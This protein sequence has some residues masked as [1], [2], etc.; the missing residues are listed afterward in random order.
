V[1]EFTERGQSC[2]LE[3][4]V[5]GD[6]KNN[7]HRERYNYSSSQGS[8]PPLFACSQRSFSRK[9]DGANPARNGVLCLSS[10]MGWGR[11]VDIRDASA[12][13]GEGWT[14]AVR[15]FAIALNRGREAR[16]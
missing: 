5:S 10:S 1:A 11:R 3:A 16:D 9:P 15:A 13:K 2:Y 14:D 8:S 4:R 7:Q 6:Y 12:S